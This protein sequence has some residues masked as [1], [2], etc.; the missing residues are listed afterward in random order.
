MKAFIPASPL[1]I[2]SALAWSGPAAADTAYQMR[3]DGLAC[4]YCAYGIEKK[5]KQID[6]VDQNSL[7][8]DLNSGLVRVQVADGISLSDERLRQL[9]KDA[10]VSLRDVQRLP[11]D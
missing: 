5:F 9:F 7:D 1:L 10:G 2:A 11:V 8:I 6:G 3:V 4:A